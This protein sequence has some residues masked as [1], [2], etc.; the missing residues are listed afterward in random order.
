MLVGRDDREPVLRGQLGAAVALPG[1]RAA[2][3]RRRARAGA[4]AARARRRA[5]HRRTRPRVDDDALEFLAARSGGDARTAL[6]RAR[7]RLRDRR[8]QGGDRDAARGRGR[9]P[10]QRDPLR[11]GRRPPLRP[12]LGLDQVHARLRPRRL[13]ALPGGDARGRRGPALHRAPDGHPRERGHRQRRPARARGGGQRRAR[14]RARRA[15]RVRA[16]PRPGGGLPGARAEVERLLRGARPRARVGARARHARAAARRCGA[17]PT[18]ARRSSAAASATTTRTTRPEGVVGAGADARRGDRRALPRAVR[19]RR[20]ARAAR[21]A[22]AHPQARAA[23][24]DR[25]YIRAMEAAVRPV[26]ERPPSSSRSARSTAPALGAVADARART[27]VQAVVDDVASVQ[28]FW[29]Q[30]PLGDRARYM[31]RAAPGDHRPARR[32]GR[33]AQPRAGQADQRVAT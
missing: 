27:Q 15:A 22:R 9:A 25:K 23:A 33:A 17:P 5:R 32:A 21:A 26:D 30:L 11:Q 28:P 29:A 31:R 19:A 12:D 20:G 24:T 3:A 18:R 7:A 1:L 13:A 2:R 6:S 4:A 10:A 8:A 14:R 16:Q